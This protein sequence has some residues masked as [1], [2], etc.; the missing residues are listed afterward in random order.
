M[1]T[2]LEAIWTPTTGTA[3]TV[4][5]VGEIGAGNNHRI[6]GFNKETGAREEF[7][8]TNGSLVLTAK[9]LEALK[10]ASRN[11]VRLSVKG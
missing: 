8:D 6:V 3:I 2:P 4:Y 5:Y 1:T 10:E 7:N 11:T 9:G